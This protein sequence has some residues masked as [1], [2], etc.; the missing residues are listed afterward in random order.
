MEK[1]Q[2]IT[3]PVL[4]A[5]QPKI[6]AALKRVCEENGLQLELGNA[7]FMSDKFW[8]KATFSVDTGGDFKPQMEQDFISNC[9]RWGMEPSDFGKSFTTFSRKTYTIVGGRPRATKRQI[10]GK[11]NRTGKEF[12]FS[13]LEVA[14][15][16]KIA[17]EKK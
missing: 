17:K 6:Q 4:R 9:W 1:I 15:F 14:A 13:A 8:L 10:V 2:E 3:R 16:L 5:I 11:C 7:T 12:V